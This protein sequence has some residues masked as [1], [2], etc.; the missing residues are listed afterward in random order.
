MILKILKLIF[1]VAWPAV[2]F[3]QTISTTAGTVTFCSGAVVVPITVSNVS[4]VGGISLT[5]QYNPAYLTFT[6]YQNAHAGLSGG[7]LVVNAAGNNVYLG[8]ASTTG[9]NIASG[10]LI[11][12]KFTGTLGTS[13]LTW[14]TQTPGACEYT[15]LNGSVLAATYTNG[16]VTV[17]APPAI[18]VQPVDMTVGEGF[19]ADFT[20]SATGTSLSYLW[21]ISTNGGSTWSDLSNNAQYSGVYTNHLHIVNTTVSMNYYKYRCHIS[22]VCP[23]EL[24]SSEVTLGVYALIGNTLPTQSYCP[25][26]IV[27]PVTVNDFLNV[28]AF[29]L[30]FSINTSVLTYTGYQNLNAVLSGGNFTAN[31]AGGKVYMTW[32]RTS[33]ANLGNGTLVELKFDAVPGSSPMTWDTQTPGACEYSNLNGGIIEAVYTNGT[34]TVNTPPAVTSHPVN[35]TILAGQ[36]TTFAITATGSGLTYRWQL[37]TDGGLNFTDLSNSSTYSGTTTATLTVSN[38]TNAMNGYQYRCRVTGTC[39]PVV[40]SNPATLTVIP[41]VTVTMQNV[42]TCPPTVTMPV[43]VQEFNNVGAFSLTLNFNNTLLTFTACQNLNAALSGGNFVANAVGS[44]LYMTW[45]STAGATITNGKLFDIIFTGVPGTSSLS[46]DTQTPGACE[47]TDANGNYMYGNF[48]GASVTV[49]TPVSITTQPVDKT[50]IATQ[51][52]SFSLT[53]VGTGL[54]YQWQRST[55][56]GSS[57]TSLTNVA[58]YS[59][60]F[61]ATLTINPAAYSMNGYKFRCIVSGTCPPSV[62]SNVVTL[63]VL[64]S[65]STYVSGITSSCTGNLVVPINVVDC[66]N[67]GAIT[68]TLTFNPAQITYEGYQDPHAELTPGMLVVNGFSNKVVL[69]WASTDPAMIGSGTLIKFKFTLPSGSSTLSWDSQTPGACEYADPN[70]N[71]IPSFYYNGTVSVAANPLVVNA[72]PDVVIGVGASTQLNGSAT[73]GTGGYT[74]SWTPTSYLSDPSIAN[75]I[76]TP[77]STIT[78]TLTVTSGTCTGSNDVMVTVLPGMVLT[79]FLE[80]PY[81]GTNMNAL[82]ITHGDFPLTQPYNVAPWNYSGTE[83]VVS[84]PNA[85]VVDWVLVELRDAPTPAQATVATRVARKAAFLLKNGF[86]AGLD[87]SSALFFN[88]TP[89]YNLYAVI[90]HR[91]HLAIMSANALVNVGGNYTYNFSTAVTQVYGGSNGHKQIGTGVWGMISGDGDGNKQVNNNDKLDVWKPQAGS[92]GYKSG[93]F[94]LNWQVNNVDKVDKWKPNS[95]KS[96]QVP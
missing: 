58:P 27:I 1:I 23:P 29:S 82:L 4:N 74:Y 88:V 51:S 69:A 2:S 87:G 8:W 35:K 36:S 67:V 45:S 7:S 52:T 77:P 89:V 81:N 84:V 12:F 33:V 38:V 43:N 37:S 85:N 75:P 73:G 34:A 3:S 49:Y 19:A 17:N 6:G 63:T 28:A 30:T 61:T 68:L 54:A 93:D 76:A 57:W 21:Q 90:W 91:N 95:G 48:S 60:V 50:V 78:Y 22:G 20:V 42:N 44:K 83:Q 62:T 40:W 13:N 46:W 9:L 47:F 56:G 92:S 31:S 5:L 10:T 72:G 26:A 18:T 64:I 80:G 96:S 94:D 55:D 59:G 39:P 86:I 41:I 66:N 14:D 79:A 15:D 16:A 65:V 71:I 24:N 25:G 70:G 11:E 32:S 53:A